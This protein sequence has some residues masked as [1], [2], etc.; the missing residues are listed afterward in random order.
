MNNYD[1]RI[2]KIETVVQ[3]FEDKNNLCYAYSYSADDLSKEQLITGLTKILGITIKEIK[4]WNIYLHDSGDW[5]IFSPNYKW[6]KWL[7]QNQKELNEDT[8]K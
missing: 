2:R 3:T 8:I 4:K 1:T 5:L 6:E 7:R